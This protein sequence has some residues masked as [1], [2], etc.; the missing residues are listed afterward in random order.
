[1]RKTFIPIMLVLILFCITACGSSGTLSDNVNSDRIYVIYAEGLNEQIHMILGKPADGNY[2]ISC[3]PAGTKEYTVLDQELIVDNGSSLDCYIPGLAK[4][5]YDIKIELGEGENYACTT[6]PCIDVIKQERSGYAHFNREEGIGGYNNDGSVKEGAKILYL[7]NENKNTLTFD[8]NGTTYTGLVEILQAK[9]YM[10]D[11]LI[12]RV[13]DKITTNQW[14]EDLTAVSDPADY[15]NMFSDQYG[16]NLAG[17]PV[18]IMI[19]QVGQLY[20]YVTTPD[21]ISLSQTSEDSTAVVE[22]STDIVCQL[23]DIQVENASNI[24]IEGIGTEAMFYQFGIQFNNCDSIEV[25]NLTF[26]SVPEYGLGLSGSSEY[27]DHGW[28]WIHNNT[29]NK[30][31]NSWDNNPDECILLSTV[32]NATISYNKF[33]TVDKAIMIGSSADAHCLN[34]TL[35]H[36]YYRT[37]GNEIPVSRNSNVHSYNNYYEG[38]SRCICPLSSSYMFS[39][40]NNFNTTSQT[41]YKA[42]REDWGVVK[43]WNDIYASAQRIKLG[44]TMVSDRDEVVENACMPDGVTD[45]SKFDTDPALFYYDTENHCSDVEIMHTA[46]DVPDFVNNYS[47]AGVFVRTV[48]PE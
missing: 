19:E 45:Y 2:V 39:E 5:Q 1:M 22:D 8:I 30:G 38:C 44:V 23:N 42:F 26:D 3:R 37:V 34:M 15:A 9:Q 20:E 10:E 35:H 16:E 33:D 21:G 7:T 47:G 17:L 18:T 12:I 24:T 14:K 4:G 29:F 40:A 32:R 6:I 36:N 25:K 48:I 11:P 28:Y 46:A 43:S 31:Y 27:P 13:L 41:Y